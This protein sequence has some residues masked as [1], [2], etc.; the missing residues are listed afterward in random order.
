MSF[1]NAY[2]MVF[3]VVE[4]SIAYYIQSEF[5][6]FIWTMLNAPITKLLLK[7]RMID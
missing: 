3:V 2:E 1:K 7:G 4:D 6:M 5:L